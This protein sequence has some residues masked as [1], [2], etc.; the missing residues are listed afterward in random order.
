EDFKKAIDAVPAESWKE[1]NLNKDTVQTV[2][3]VFLAPDIDLNA[4]G[5]P[6]AI[7]LALDF[8]SVPASITQ[9]IK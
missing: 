4:D 2:L 8:E 5:K 7:S 3:E 6:D 1:I 9:V